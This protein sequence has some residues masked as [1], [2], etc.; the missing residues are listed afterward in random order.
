MLTA[1][2]IFLAGLVGRMAFQ[3][4]FGRIAARTGEE[5]PIF[6]L[7]LSRNHLIRY[8]YQAPLDLRCLDKIGNVGASPPLDFRV[9]FI[10]I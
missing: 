8:F 9:Q 2:I 10:S 3:Y 1:L 5:D 6:L 4:R 7:R